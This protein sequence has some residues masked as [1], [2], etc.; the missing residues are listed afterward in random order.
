MSGEDALGLKVDSGRIL[1][2]AKGSSESLP[3]RELG[4]RVVVSQLYS[5]V[6][7]LGVHQALRD[8][9][10]GR[11]GAAVVVVEVVHYV[12]LCFDFF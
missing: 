4:G 6:K 7:R 10:G 2:Y 3:K 5:A 8:L 12:A 9:L 1:S 11:A